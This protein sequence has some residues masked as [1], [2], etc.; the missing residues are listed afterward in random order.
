MRYPANRLALLYCR[1][2]SSRKGF[3]TKL[4]NKIELDTSC[5]GIDVLFTE[6]SLISYPLFLR[7]G[8]LKDSVENILIAGVSFDRYRMSK[9]I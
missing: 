9:K 7:N 1:G 4:L 3:A 8:W 2:R 6:A 5:E